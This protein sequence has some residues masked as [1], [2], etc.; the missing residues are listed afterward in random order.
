MVEVFLLL[1]GVPPFLHRQ[2]SK[3]LVEA[4]GGHCTDP[5]QWKN[6]STLRVLT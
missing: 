6:A 3:C 4:V 5:L 1:V 2:D